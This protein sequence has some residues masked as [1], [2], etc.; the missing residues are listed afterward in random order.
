MERV[1]Q[2][3]K[4]KQKD[5]ILRMEDLCISYG[6]NRIIKNLNFEIRRG[7]LVSFVGPSG[8]GKTTTLLG[9]AGLIKPTS[10]RILMDERE[11]EGPGADRGIVY[12]DYALYPWRTV[13]EN[14]TFGLDIKGIKQEQKE[15][16][17]HESLS[18]LKLLGHE[19]KYPSELSGGMKQR[20][21]LARTIV[22][23]PEVLLLDEAF[24]ALDQQT[25]Y[26]LENEMHKIFNK[27][28]KTV[29]NATHLLDEAILMSDRIVVFS[30]G[31][32]VET[33]DINL[34]RPRDMHGKQFI[35]LLKKV[36][37]SI[38]EKTDLELFVEDLKLV[39]ELKKG[40]REK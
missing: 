1:K 36:E 2:R 9:I 16:L 8:C 29:I 37:A 14:V 6:E 19:K 17:I 32:I 23:N 18:L 21:G 25:R 5:I 35:D 39:D 31:E 11:I 34:P 12:Q 3:K 33:F 24:S 40:K 22:N 28:G 30:E 7:E 20:V 26:R 15:K 13:Y 27:L 38:R 4:E 10:G